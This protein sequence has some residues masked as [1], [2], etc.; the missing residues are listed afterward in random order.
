MLL[1]ILQVP[2]QQ[3]PTAG[4]LLVQ[5]LR[6]WPNI[7]PPLGQ[8]WARH[9]NAPYY[10]TRQKKIVNENNLTLDIFQSHVILIRFEVRIIATD[11][12]K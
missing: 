1:L 3:T 7:D 10:T 9:T 8:C 6:R 2:S 12:W 4:S 11:E 5:R